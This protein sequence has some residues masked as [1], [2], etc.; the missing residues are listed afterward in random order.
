MRFERDSPTTKLLK[1]FRNVSFE[2]V[3]DLD[4]PAPDI[5]PKQVLE[6]KV[7]TGANQIASVNDNMGQ[8]TQITDL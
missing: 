2:A 3:V 6:G 8:K 5:L 4:V 1:K 7:R